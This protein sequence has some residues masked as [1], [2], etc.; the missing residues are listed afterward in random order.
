MECARC[1][2]R[3]LVAIALFSLGCAKRELSE[4]EFLERELARVSVPGVRG[5]PV[6]AVLMRSYMST[7]VST[8]VVF[9]LWEDGRVVFRSSPLD[10]AGE[11]RTFEIDAARAAQVRS[12][13]ASLLA[14]REPWGPASPC[15]AQQEIVCR[16]PAGLDYLTMD[17]TYEPLGTELSDYDLP[18]YWS[19]SEAALR[20]AERIAAWPDALHPTSYADDRPALQLRA[21]IETRLADLLKPHLDAPTISDVRLDRR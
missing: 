1:G 11:F 20:R 18:K 12:D 13:I 17:Y 2:W 21:A 19:G 10:A 15:S 6:V 4:V 9:A 8:G 3:S 14:S 5:E 7:L 16:G